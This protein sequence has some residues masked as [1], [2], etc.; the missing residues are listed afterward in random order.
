MIDLYKR[1]GQWVG[2]DLT[3]SIISE[4]TE[5][6]GEYMLGI[7]AS[8]NNSKKIVVF[9]LVVTN[10]QSVFAY[11]YLFKSFIEIMGSSP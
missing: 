7:F 6:N 8:T 1:Y 5:D 4:R 2:F 11:K 10:S 9:G 3:F